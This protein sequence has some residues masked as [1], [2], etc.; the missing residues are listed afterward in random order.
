MRLGMDFTPCTFYYSP[1]CVG[2]PCTRGRWAARRARPV[3]GCWRRASRGEWRPSSRADRTPNRCRRRRCCCCC[4]TKDAARTSSASSRTT[5][6]RHARQRRFSL[7]GIHEINYSLRLVAV[8]SMKIPGVG[9]FEQALTVLQSTRHSQGLKLSPPQSGNHFISRKKRTKLGEKK[10]SAL[11]DNARLTSFRRL[12][13]VCR[14][15]QA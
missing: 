3:V 7:H 1:W 8:L 13:S 12:I 9:C 4:C 14:V 11:S 2:R 10:F 6:C 15:H 5:A